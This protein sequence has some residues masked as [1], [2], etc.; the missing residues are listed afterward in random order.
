MKVQRNKRDSANTDAMRERVLAWAKR[1]GVCVGQIHVR[2]MRT[3]WASCSTAGRI[4]LDAKVAALPKELSDYVIVHELLH[5]RVPNHGKLWKCLM[6]AHLG[7]WEKIEDRLRGQAAMKC[8]MDLRDY[9]C[10]SSA[11]EVAQWT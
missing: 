7:E 8:D 11:Q 3:K 9:G 1:L 6:R 2:Q 10:E 4:T 5:L